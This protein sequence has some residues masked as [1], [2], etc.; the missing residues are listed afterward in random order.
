MRHKRTVNGNKIV[1]VEIKGTL[2]SW[3]FSSFVVFLTSDYFRY[4]L[5]V[6]SYPNPCAIDNGGCSSL[7]LLNS[8]SYSCSCP[9]GLFPVKTGNAIKCEGE[10]IKI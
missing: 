3:D 7:C 10:V 2:K 1:F 8:K 9:D 5:I 4:F 6:A